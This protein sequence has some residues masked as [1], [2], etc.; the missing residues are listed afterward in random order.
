MEKMVAK[1]SGGRDETGASAFR[2]SLNTL[3]DSK[4][5][6]SNALILASMACCK[7]SRERSWGMKKWDDGVA[8]EV[9]HRLYNSFNDVR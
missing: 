1:I 9:D 3:T 7:I 5:D 4:K 6:S 2:S 8:L